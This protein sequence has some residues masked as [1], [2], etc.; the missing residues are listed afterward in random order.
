MQSLHDA[1]ESVSNSLDLAVETP[2]SL[3]SSYRT[4][5]STHALILPTNDTVSQRSYLLE[6]HA[7]GLYR[8]SPFPHHP[9]LT[10]Q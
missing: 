9:G 2:F 4:T 5:P 8:E 3:S 10:Q 1:T 6:L 7:S